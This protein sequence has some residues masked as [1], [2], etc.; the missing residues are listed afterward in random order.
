LKKENPLLS[1]GKKKVRQRKPVFVQA[2]CN[3]RN[4]GGPRYL[5]PLA[6]QSRAKK[7]G[8]KNPSL[9]L[10]EKVFFGR[11]TV[12]VAIRDVACTMAALKG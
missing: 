9:S 6:T 11:V 3:V 12:F 5:L 7:T 2:Q 8:K 1:F 10:G 4:S